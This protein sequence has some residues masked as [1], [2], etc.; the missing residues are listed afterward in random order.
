MILSDVCYNGPDTLAEP[1]GLNPDESLAR[2]SPA[3]LALARS[4]HRDG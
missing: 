3:L 4:G 1:V 2:F